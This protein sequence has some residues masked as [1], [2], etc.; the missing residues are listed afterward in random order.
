MKKF[1]F[2]SAL[3]L[4]ITLNLACSKTSESPSQEKNNQPQGSEQT[5]QKTTPLET[6]LSN[7]KDALRKEDRVADVGWSHCEPEN[8]VTYCQKFE[9]KFASGKILSIENKGK[10]YTPSSESLYQSF[11]SEQGETLTAAYSAHCWLESLDEA[12]KL[13][14]K[15]Q[16]YGPM[17]SKKY[18]FF[19][20][21]EIGATGFNVETG[22]CYT[23]WQE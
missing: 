18:L 12:E 3:V 20:F 21:D 15:V 13:H 23:S 6:F 16:S 11:K 4:P 7:V 22:E 2:F 17:F 5:L 9:I 10:Y 8:E 19:T 1:H 14:G